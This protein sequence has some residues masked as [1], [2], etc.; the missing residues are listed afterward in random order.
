MKTN[1]F[2]FL[3]SL[4]CLCPLLAQRESSLQLFSRPGYDLVTYAMASPRQN[5][6]VMGGDISAVND[7]LRQGFLLAVDSLGQPRWSTM[8]G[9]QTNLFSIVDLK[10]DAQG[11][12][13]VLSANYGS[14]TLGGVDMHVSKWDAQGNLIWQKNVGTNDD[15]DPLGLLP[16]P[17]GNVLVYGATIQGAGFRDAL[18]VEITTQGAIVKTRQLG[19]GRYDYPL[20]AAFDHINQQVVLTGY[21]NSFSENNDLWVSALDLATFT[22]HW[23]RQVQASAS[24]QETG[25]ALDVTPTGDIRVLGKIEGYTVALQLSPDGILSNAYR[26]E[27]GE[28][29]TAT[30]NSSGEWAILAGS[31][32]L[33]LLDQH[34]IPQSGG[35]FQGANQERATQTFTIDT[36][37]RPWGVGTYRPNGATNSSLALFQGGYGINP[38]CGG[39][40]TAAPKPDTLPLSIHT[41]TMNTGSKGS[42]ADANIPMQSLTLTQAEICRETC[43]SPALVSSFSLQNL[44]LTLDASASQQAQRFLFDFGD[45][46]TP[47]SSPDPF[48][49]YR[50]SQAGTY[51][52]CITAIGNCQSTTQC[53]SVSIGVTAAQEVPSEWKILVFPNPAKDWINWSSH[54]RFPLSGQLFNGLG[55]PITPKTFENRISLE[56]IPFGLYYL[57]LQDIQGRRSTFPV[58]KQ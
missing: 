32:R 31:G 12:L 10:A 33:L 51:N 55:Q 1:I 38:G 24:D 40:S 13:W 20:A 42:V 57:R 34:N 21:T 54:P 2:V 29:R 37:N 23:V 39:Y 3:L 5:L 15:D 26:L 9:D 50:Y 46:S 27:N 30:S 14:G 7:F 43:S 6:M 41:I 36:Q 44:T 19:S 17:S 28:V 4:V 16:L 49:V 11:A 18:L 8:L 56:H 53:Q 58:L 47:L 22:P 35:Y 25:L 45:G 52:V 48:G